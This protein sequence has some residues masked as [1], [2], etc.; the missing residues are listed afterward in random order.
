M[1][2]AELIAFLTENQTELSE[3]LDAPLQPD[4]IQA[5]SNL[6]MKGGFAEI[7]D[8]EAAKTQSPLPFAVIRWS[9]SSAAQIA[10]LIFC[11][12]CWLLLFC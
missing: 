9:F 5:L 12:I 3:I 2:E 10:R 6:I 8:L 1:D 11:A 4:D 7:T